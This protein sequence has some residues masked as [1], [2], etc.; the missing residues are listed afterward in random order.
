M[1]A[2]GFTV[3]SFW[4][5]WAYRGKV[6]GHPVG[7]Y[8][9]GFGSG[10]FRLRLPVVLANTGA[11]TRVVVDARIRIVSGPKESTLKWQTTRRSLKPMSDDVED[12]AAA[13]TLGNRGAERH[14]MEF[15]GP[16]ADG[17]PKPQDYEYCLDVRLDRDLAWHM[18]SR[19]VL[20]F[21]HLVHPD[22]YITYANSAEACSEDEVASAR[23]ALLAYARKSGISTTWGD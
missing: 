23:Q 5:L 1:A 17:V 20:R 10:D 9:A 7:S 8:S 4:F 2:L 11:R 14:F 22:R 3:A 6:V 21:G 19:D 18:A 13:F 12:F 16:L 15:V